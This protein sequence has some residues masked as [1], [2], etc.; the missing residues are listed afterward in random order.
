MSKIIHARMIPYWTLENMKQAIKSCHALFDKQ[1]PMWDELYMLGIITYGKLQKTY[2][3][4][5]AY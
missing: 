4:N 1:Q 5:N 2:R 3:K